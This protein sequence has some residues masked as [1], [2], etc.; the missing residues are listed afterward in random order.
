[1]PVGSE[2]A[3]AA[4]MAKRKMLP[5]GARFSGRLGAE[6]VENALDRELIRPR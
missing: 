6:G 5:Y 1:M 3:R 4:G 2:G